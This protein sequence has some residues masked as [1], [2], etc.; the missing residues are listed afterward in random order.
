M[1]DFVFVTGNQK[2]A[3]YLSELLGL[4]VE[5][6]KADVDEIQTTD[7]KALVE[8]KAKQAYEIIGKPV[9]IED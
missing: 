6:Y 3:D 7:V 8:H 5:H 1:K 2:K 9:L 4:P